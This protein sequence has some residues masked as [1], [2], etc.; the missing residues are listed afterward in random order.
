MSSSSA[1]LVCQEIF[2]FR[3]LKNTPQF[4]FFPAQEN[5][6]SKET[7]SV[8]SFFRAQKSRKIQFRLLVYLS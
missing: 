5:Y 8:G 3:N 7:K 2:L 1:A 4:V 6:L